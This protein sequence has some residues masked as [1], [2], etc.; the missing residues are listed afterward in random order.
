M[1]NFAFHQPTTLREAAGLLAGSPGARCIAGGQTLVAMLNAKLIEV[2]ALISLDRISGLDA[3][4]DHGTYVRIGAMATHRAIAKSD[5]LTRAAG[6]LKNAANVVA[7]PAVRNFGTIGGTLAHADP[8]TDYP[9]AVI[10]ANATIVLSGV[11]GDREVSARE[12]FLDYFTTVAKPDELISS[13]KVPKG[14]INS[15][16][17]YLK[18]SRVDGDYATVAVAVALAVQN[19]RCNE[20]SIALNSCGPKPVF[21]PKADATLVG[22]ACEPKAMRAAAD[23]LVR[24]S[25]PVDDVRGSASYRLA[26]I[27]NLVERAVMT[28]WSKTK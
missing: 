23:A 7:N 17:H 12:F 25:D 9:A 5:V 28:A 16:G 15:A 22:S 13:V 6:V 18:F 19:G 3:I 2:P 24:A 27:P 10:A 11:A 21:D 1:T 26:I 8:S 4:E 14:P 20:A